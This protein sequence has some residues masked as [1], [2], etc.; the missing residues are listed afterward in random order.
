MQ[1]KEEPE[2]D[3][4]APKSSFG[5]AAAT[6]RKTEEKK[7][8]PKV[9]SHIPLAS[10]YEVVDDWDCMLNQT[11][12]GHNNNKY[13]VIQLLKRGSAFYVWTR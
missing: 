4:D 10:S 7:R 11:N 9:D 13:Y 6:L 1:V 12:I 2:E 5:K 3:T 8:K